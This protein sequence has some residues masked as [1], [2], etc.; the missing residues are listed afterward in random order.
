MTYSI[1]EIREDHCIRKRNNSQNYT[2]FIKINS[3]IRKGM[4]TARDKWIQMQCKSIYDDMTYGRHNKRAYQILE[5]P[6]KYI[7]KKHVNH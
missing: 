4:Q 5:N 1:N 7:T 3:T 6:H 2:E